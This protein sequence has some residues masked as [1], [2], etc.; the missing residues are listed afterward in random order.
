MTELARAP[1]GIRGLDEMLQ[2]G[3][4]ASSIA[5]IQGAPGT[6]KTTFGMQFLH[7]GVKAHN[8]AGLLVTFEPVS[9]THLTLPTIYSV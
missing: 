3:L 1:M 2:G 5:L 6:G 8:E 7:E 9:Y 4:I